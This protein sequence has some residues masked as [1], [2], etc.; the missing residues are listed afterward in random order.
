M[1]PCPTDHLRDAEDVFRSR[2]MLPVVG[3]VTVYVQPARLGVDVF[4]ACDVLAGWVPQALIDAP[5]S[6]NCHCSG[7]D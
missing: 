7:S 1:V 2:W 4:V 5:K 3:E 6:E